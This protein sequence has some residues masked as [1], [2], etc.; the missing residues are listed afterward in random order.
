MKRYIVFLTASVLLSAALLFSVLGSHHTVVAE[1][2]NTVY[3]TDGGAGRTDGSS[4]ANA[5]DSLDEAIE[6]LASSGGTV[7]VC[8]PLTV[9]SFTEPTHAGDINITSVHGGVDYRN[10]ASAVFALNGNYTASGPVTF[11]GITVLTSGATRV[12]FGNGHPV[13]FGEGVTCEIDGTGG[14][15]YPYIFGGTNKKSGSIAGASVT[16]SVVFSGG[17]VVFSGGLVVVSGAFVVVS[18]GLFISSFI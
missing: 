16:V 5:L 11:D 13:T 6:A 4:P 7:V 18:G 9:S 12:F 2:K 1:N 14:S 10:T 3:V 17:L 8:G 15:S